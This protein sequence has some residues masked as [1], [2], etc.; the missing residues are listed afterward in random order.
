MQETQV[1]SLGQEDPL[2]KEIAPHSS[3]LAWEIPWTEGTSRLLYSPR[4]GK[5]VQCNLVTKQVDNIIAKILEK[6][7]KIYK[8]SILCFINVLHSYIILKE[9][10]WKSEFVL[11]MQF[12]SGKKKY[13]TDEPIIKEN[14][15]GLYQKI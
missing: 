15:L 10:K 12:F 5:G 7:T 14:E 1:W 11:C 4:G 13:P 6:I 8:V 3:T 9:K 2:A